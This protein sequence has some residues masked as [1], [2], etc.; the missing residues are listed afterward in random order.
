MSRQLFTRT[1][2]YA[3]ILLVAGLGLSCSDDRERPASP[4][5]I[6]CPVETYI[7]E[8]A[9]EFADQLLVEQ[10]FD[11]I[12]ANYS[13]NSSIICN[14]MSGLFPSVDPALCQGAGVNEERKVYTISSNDGSPNL[15]AMDYASALRQWVQSPVSGASDAHGPGPPKLYTIACTVFPNRPICGHGVPGE[16]EFMLVFSK[17]PAGSTERSHLFLRLTPGATGWQISGTSG[18]STRLASWTRR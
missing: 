9:A 13:A 17:I 11:W 2:F 5:P 12:V 15:L 18:R 3:A 10:D 1:V 4:T 8:R 6:P 7:C 14:D 16:D